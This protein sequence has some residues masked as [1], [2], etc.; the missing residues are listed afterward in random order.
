VRSPAAQASSWT[1]RAATSGLGHATKGSYSYWKVGQY[2]K[3]GG[4][5]GRKEGEVHFAG[6]HTSVDFQGYLNG[7]VETGERAAREI[8]ADLK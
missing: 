5:E 3:F 1:R 2:T 6:E 8:L 4:I 7:G